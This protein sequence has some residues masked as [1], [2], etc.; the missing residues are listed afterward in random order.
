MKGR[1]QSLEL[2]AARARF[3]AKFIANASD[4]AVY[5]L[6]FSGKTKLPS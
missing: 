5:T 2:E 4:D 3:I 6:D 1:K